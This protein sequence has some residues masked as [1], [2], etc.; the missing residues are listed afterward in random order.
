MSIDSSILTIFCNFSTNCIVCFIQSILFLF[1]FS[2]DTL[3][4]PKRIHFTDTSAPPSQAATCTR[5]SRY[6]CWRLWIP[7]PSL[8]CKGAAALYPDKLQFGNIR[9]SENAWSAAYS[10]TY[11]SIRYIRVGLPLSLWISSLSVPHNP[12]VVSLSMIWFVWRIFTLRRSAS[13]PP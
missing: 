12:A 5:Q 8:L 1:F 13:S 10:D 9:F 6:L 3:C 7:D 11:I 4:F 2:T